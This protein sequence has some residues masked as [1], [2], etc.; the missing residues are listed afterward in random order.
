MSVET[1]YGVVGQ[2]RH[3]IERDGTEVRVRGVVQGSSGCSAVAFSG[4][5][6]D[7]QSGEI[8]L[9]RVSDSFVC[10]DA[11]TRVR[12][13]LTL[14]FA[15][16]PPSD[17]AVTVSEEAVERPLVRGASFEPGDRDEVG[18][19]HEVERDPRLN[20]A[21]VSGTVRAPD[22]C[23][24]FQYAGTKRDGDRATVVLESFP[25][26]QGCAQVVTPIDYEVVLV[27]PDGLPEEIDVAVR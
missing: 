5:S 8:G 12:Y 7:P 19:Q 1:E 15:D 22:A 11:M 2:P 16:E 9:S 10:T 14:S 13:G 18:P 24:G 27:F 25:T 23:T 21:T 26:A 4:A 17:L 6:A 3:E 20:R